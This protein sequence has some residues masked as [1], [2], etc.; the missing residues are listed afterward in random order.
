MSGFEQD[1]MTTTK[2][3]IAK[4]A[5]NTNPGVKL[6]V[7]CRTALR[8]SGEESAKPSHRAR[9]PRNRADSSKRRSSLA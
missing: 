7:V 8:T 2:Q 9:K 1:L 3:M 4:S 6:P 5:R